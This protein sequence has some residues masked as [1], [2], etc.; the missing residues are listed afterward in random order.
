MKHFKLSTNI[1]NTSLCLCSLAASVDLE[2][3]RAEEQLAPES[4]PE[5]SINAT[6]PLDALDRV[7]AKTISLNICQSTISNY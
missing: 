4:V 6:V 1:M 2:Q 5:E 7:S 3:D